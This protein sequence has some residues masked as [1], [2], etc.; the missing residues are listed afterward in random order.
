MDRRTIAVFCLPGTW[1]HET[2]R[3]PIPPK[4]NAT[5]LCA[6][7]GRAQGAVLGG[8]ANDSTTDAGDVAMRQAPE[9]AIRSHIPDQ[10]QR[11][12]SAAAKRRMTQGE[13]P[14]KKV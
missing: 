1:A 8:P 3:N 13:H 2:A 4:E 10:C 9:K 11:V 5:A 14:S 6:R 12:I 7:T